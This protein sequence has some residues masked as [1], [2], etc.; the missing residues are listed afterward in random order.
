M[1]LKE[2]TSGM[3]EDLKGVAWSGITSHHPP[4]KPACSFVFL[5]T[6]SCVLHAPHLE[7]VLGLQPTEENPQPTAQVKATGMGQSTRRQE[8]CIGS[9]RSVAEH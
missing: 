3:N 5:N 8:M 9:P 6:V 4:G 7:A 1:G 2:N